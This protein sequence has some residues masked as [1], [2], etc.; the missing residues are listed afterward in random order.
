MRAKMPQM[1]GVKVAEEANRDYEVVWREGKTL[2][3]T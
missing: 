1:A 2:R 3:I